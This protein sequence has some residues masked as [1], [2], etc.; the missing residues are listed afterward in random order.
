MPDK[1]FVC[2]ST[3]DRM[4]ISDQVLLMFASFLCRVQSALSGWVPSEKTNVQILHHLLRVIWRDLYRAVHQFQMINPS[5]LQIKEKHSP[6]TQR[7]SSMEVMS[8]TAS[9][10]TRTC[11]S[12]CSL[13]NSILSWATLLWGLAARANAALITC[14]HPIT[15]IKAPLQH[16]HQPQH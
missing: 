12:H 13:N 15:A 11:F 7:K 8:S 2:F 16:T 5:I 9:V 3:C 10:R 14:N 6:D 4:S 1:P